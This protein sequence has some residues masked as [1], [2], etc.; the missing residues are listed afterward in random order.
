MHAITHNSGLNPEAAAMLDARNEIP[1]KREPKPERFDARFTVRLAT[2]EA[3]E[4]RNLADDRAKVRW[5]GRRVLLRQNIRRL[6]FRLGEEC[7]RIHQVG[8]SPSQT[9]RTGQA[10]RHDHIHGQRQFQFGN[11]A[12]LQRLYATAILEH[13]EEDFPPAAIPINQFNHHGKGCYAAIAQIAQQAPLH[14]LNTRRRIHFLG[15]DTGEN[16]RFE[17]ALL[18]YLRFIRAVT[19]NCDPFFEEWED[20]R[21]NRRFIGK[22][23]TQTAVKNDNGM[24]A[25]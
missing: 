18:S 21:K 13:V 2:E 9:Y 4:N 3:A 6:P 15:D 20:R 16:R 24:P 17:C 7:A 25:W 1:D 23:P 10:P 11:A 8:V 22:L 5:L 12:Q 14:P 19:A